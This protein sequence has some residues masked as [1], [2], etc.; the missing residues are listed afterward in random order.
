M[1]PRNAEQVHYVLEELLSTIKEGTL[2]QSL[3][4]V[5]QNKYRIR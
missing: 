4:I 5:D 2:N 1:R 3:V